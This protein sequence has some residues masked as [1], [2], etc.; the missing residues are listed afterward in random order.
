M[1]KDND[2]NR[3]SPFAL[4]TKEDL[5]HIPKANAAYHGTNLTR[6]FCSAHERDLASSKRPTRSSHSGKLRRSILV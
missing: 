4:R 2:P 1:A 5:Q 3:L 6:A